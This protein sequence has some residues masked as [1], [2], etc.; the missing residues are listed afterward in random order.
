VTKFLWGKEVKGKNVLPLLPWF[1]CP[2]T[3]KKMLKFNFYHDGIKRWS[4]YKVKRSWVTD[5]INGLKPLWWE[6][7]SYKREEFGSLSLSF[8]LFWNVILLPCHNSG[9]RLSTQWPLDLRFPSLQKCK[10]N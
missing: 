10:P 3:K 5:L 8:A 4:H 1:Q 2:S 6:W 9:R 7:V